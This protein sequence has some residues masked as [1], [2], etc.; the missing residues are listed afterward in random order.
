MK[1][2]DRIIEDLQ[3]Q[4]IKRLGERL[5]KEVLITKPLSNN[6]NLEYLYDKDG[7]LIYKRKIKN[8][9]E[10][11]R[12][13]YKYDENKIYVSY[14][15]YNYKNQLDL[16]TSDIISINNYLKDNEQIEV[17]NNYKYDRKT[18]RRFAYKTSCE[19][20]KI[21]GLNI[22]L[23]IDSSDIYNKNNNEL[24]VQ[25]LLQLNK[26]DIL[27]ININN[28]TMRLNYSYPDM[29]A[30]VTIN[31]INDKI[32]SMKCESDNAPDKYK[33]SI[34]YDKDGFLSEVKETIMSNLNWEYTATT[35]YD[36]KNMM[37]VE[38]RSRAKKVK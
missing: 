30:I 19:Y 27:N 20:K 37:I 32:V 11:F 23:L 12:Y 26:V 29:K 7:K 5:N 10:E 4:D 34:K 2:I 36:Y 13:T 6:S 8:S 18:D 17:I 21:S 24:I 22:L 15:G 14:K 38:E 9:N 35:T 25:R 28:K 33:V 16:Y 31:I 1:T 3:L